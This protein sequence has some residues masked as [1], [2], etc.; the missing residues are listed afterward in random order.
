MAGYY[1]KAKEIDPLR[2][3]LRELLKKNHPD[4]GG[5]AAKYAEILAE[6]ELTE[7]ELLA[8]NY[9]NQADFKREMQL[10]KDYFKLCELL[11]NIGDIN[12]EIIGN[13]FWISG[14]GISQIDDILKKL[15]FHYSTK[16]RRYF[17]DV[18]RIGKE[19][20]SGYRSTIEDIRQRY[21][22][23][24]YKTGIG[25]IGTYKQKKISKAEIEKRLKALINT[26]KKRVPKKR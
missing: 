10:S 1:F 6:F 4:K 16:H 3:E 21:A 7:E 23:A 15:N 25:S 18:S 24:K 19:K 9:P 22:T 12:A 26:L 8:K 5:D 11:L 2:T 17:I 20:K 13:F 14:K